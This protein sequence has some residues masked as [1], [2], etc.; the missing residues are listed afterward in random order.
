MTFK[1]KKII[2]MTRDEIVMELRRI[3]LN[4]ARRFNRNLPREEALHHALRTSRPVLK[5]VRD[6][7]NDH[8]LQ[9]RLPELWP[10][11]E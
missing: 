11:D 7:K 10:H 4:D 9:T 5:I 2:D 3:S 8:H 1:L 6:K